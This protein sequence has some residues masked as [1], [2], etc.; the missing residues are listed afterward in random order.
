MWGLKSL[1]FPRIN[2]E[3]GATVLQP[4]CNPGKNNGNNRNNSRKHP[5]RRAVV[6]V[7]NVQSP[8]NLNLVEGIYVSLVVGG[9]DNTRKRQSN[10]ARP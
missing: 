3:N 8:I 2:F 10:V 7:K 5:R 1:F 6:K 9:Y 4:Y